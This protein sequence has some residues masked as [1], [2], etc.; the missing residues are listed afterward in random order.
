METPARPRVTLKLATSLDGRIATAS[1]E[2]RWITGPEARAAVHDMRAAHDA[3]LVGAQ[4]A[5]VDDPELTARTDPPPPR[6]PLRVVLD[7]RLRLAPESRLLRTLAAGPVLIIA[8]RDADR[9]AKARLEAAGAKVALVARGLE[10]VELRAALAHLSEKESV[11]RLFVEGGGAIAASFLAA[12]LVDRLEWFRAPLVLGA[13]ARPGV[14]PLAIAALAKAPRF[15]RVDLKE[16]GAD[17]W[18]SYQRA[19]AGATEQ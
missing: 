12:G 2:S 7:T 11:A 19:E 9:A 1:G 18:E 13:E 15:A 5:L 10:G 8:G 4:T 6:Q 14:G 17:I 3:V 16:I